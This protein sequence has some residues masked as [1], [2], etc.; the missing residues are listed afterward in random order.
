MTTAENGEKQLNFTDNANH[1]KYVKLP[2]E[3]IEQGDES[4]TIDMKFNTSQKAFAWIFNLGTKG[5]A[6]YVFLNPI[7]AWGPTVLSVK[8]SVVSGDEHNVDV[9][10]VIEVGADTVATMVFNDNQTAQLYINGKL[11]GSVNHGCNITDILENGV[12]DPADAIGYLGL[13]LYGAD[14]GYE[15]T[16]SRFDV[17]NYAMTEKE[18]ALLYVDKYLQM[19]DEDRV[20]ADVAE[21]KKN[22]K[23]GELTA[24]ELELPDMGMNGSKI[25]WESSKKDV[26]AEDGA[27]TRPAI[28]KPDEAVTLTATVSRGE[29][30]QKVTFDFN[31][32][33][34]TEMQ[35]MEDFELGTVDVT[36]SYYD[37]ISQKDIDFLKTFDA[38]RL[39]SRFRGDGRSGYQGCRPLYRMGEQLHWRPYAWTLYDGVRAGISDGG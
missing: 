33:A 13:S 10:D 11:I 12:T 37:Q 29:V 30:S 17:Y 22:L 16:I 23:E 9:G 24:S 34:V 4:F 2:Q 21:L 27:V 26:I 6:D 28:G 5:T 32:L 7:R 36:N 25:V 19:A 31:V 8:S 39:L 35:G 1:S 15:G 20:A 3:I 18:V 38:D 14:P